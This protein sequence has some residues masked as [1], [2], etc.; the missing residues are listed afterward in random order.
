MLECQQHEPALVGL[1]LGTLVF[2]FVGRGGKK[3]PHRV[4]YLKAS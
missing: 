2:F 3:G 4:I 1:D